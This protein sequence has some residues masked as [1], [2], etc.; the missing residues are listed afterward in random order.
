MKTLRLFGM[1]LMAVLMCVNFASCNSEEV[2]P[3]DPNQDKYITVGLDC[4]GEYLDIKDS[5]LSR[6]VGDDLYLIQVYSVEENG[7]TT[8]YAY[9]NFETSLNGLTI[10][11]IQGKKYDFKVAIQVGGCSSNTSIYNTTFIYSSSEG[12]AFRGYL[13]YTNK[14]IS[15]NRAKE[16]FYGELDN[17]IPKEGIN[18]EIPTKRVSYAAKFIGENLTEGTLDITVKRSFEMGNYTDYITLTPTVPISDQIYSFIDTYQAW[19]GKLTFIGFDSEGKEITEYREYTSEKTVEIKWNKEDGTVIPF[20]TYKVTFKRNVRTTI[21]INVA[22]LPSVNNGITV[23]R[24][25]TP[26][27]DDEND[28]LIEG[29]EITEIPV[30]SEP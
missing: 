23:T 15:I 11:L 4:V 21:R 1:A 22:K 13:S 26:M 24:E 6:A 10:K 16:G 17:F 9:G 2:T 19:K 8:P 25:D 29:G 28:F 27:S 30:N 18:V 3:D 7:E 14:Y 12:E 20:G 5:P